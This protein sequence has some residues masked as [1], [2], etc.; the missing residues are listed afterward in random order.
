MHSL[1]L[2]AP[3]FVEKE[4]KDVTFFLIHHNVKTILFKMSTVDFA[5]NL[6]FPGWPGRRLWVSRALPKLASAVAAIGYSNL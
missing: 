1:T 2:L 5:F 3:D 6:R 4:G